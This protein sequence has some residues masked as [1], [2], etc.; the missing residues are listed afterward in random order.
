MKKR[1]LALLCVATMIVGASMSVCAG[2]P[3]KSAADLKND[4]GAS[5]DE[6][7]GTIKSENLDLPATAEARAEA[8]KKAEAAIV[9]N[10][11]VKVEPLQQ[12]DVLAVDKVIKSKSNEMANA[13]QEKAI[14]ANLEGKAGAKVEFKVNLADNEDL[15]V[16]HITDP[17]T[18]K[19]EFVPWTREANGNI[20]FKA[21]SYSLFAII[22]ILETGEDV[23][24]STDGG[25]APATT[26]TGATTPTSP[27]TAD[28]WQ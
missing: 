17:A 24:G 13:V 2:S 15:W 22:P 21:P 18:G 12:A 26:G 1:F 28:V 9:P 4:Y 14:Y 16:I 8:T 5:F 11:D 3:S 10:S 27:K 7:K 20:S 6:T 19:Y 25:S 23:S